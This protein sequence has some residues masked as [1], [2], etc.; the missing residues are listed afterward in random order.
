[1]HPLSTTVYGA[2]PLLIPTVKV[3]EPPTQFVAAAG[4]I[5]QLGLGTQVWVA[6]HG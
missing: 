2:V 4:E 6:V 1:M 3:L 5:T